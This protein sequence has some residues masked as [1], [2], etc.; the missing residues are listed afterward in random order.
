MKARGQ[1]LRGE[2]KSHRAGELELQLML[3]GLNGKE[4][5]KAMLF[6]FTWRT[7]MAA[8]QPHDRERGFV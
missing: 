1:F 3:R 4:K 7:D 6:K 8:K 5:G 2:K